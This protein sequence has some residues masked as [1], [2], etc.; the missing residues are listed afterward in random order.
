[1]RRSKR[2]LERGSYPAG[3]LVSMVVSFLASLAHADTL[4][5]AFPTAEGFGACTPGGRGG[6]VLFVTTLEDY[7][8]SKEQSIEGSFRA[9]VDTDGPR[10]ILFRVGGTIALKADLWI[11]KPYATIAGQSAPGGGICIRDYQLVLATN[12]VI[13]RH[14]RIRSGDKTRQEQMA[15]GIFGGNNSIVDHCSMSWAIDEV[16]SSFGT[17]HNL[18]VQW[19]IISEGLSKSFHPKGEHSKGSILQGDGGVTLHHCIYAHNAARNARV[20]SILLDFRNNIVYDWGYRCGYTSGGPI[21]SNYIN[22]Y[23]KPGPSTRKSAA[24]RVFDPGDDMPRMYLTGNVLEGNENATQYN[25]L[26]V[27]SPDEFNREEMRN[28]ILVSEAFAVPDVKT[29]S[30]AEALQRVILKAGA[31]KPQRDSAD[32]RLMDEVRNG[33]GTIIDSTDQVGGW[34]VLE[35]GAPLADADND[36]MPDDWETKYNL[37]ATQASAPDSD[38]DKDGYT[39][40]EEFLN[41]TNPREPEKS[42][43][44]DAPFFRF[45]QTRAIELVAKGDADEAARAERAHENQRNQ[46]ERMKKELRVA[47]DVPPGPDAKR[48]TLNL[49]SAEQL[50]LVRIRAGSFL[51]GSPEGEGGLE[52]ERPQHKVNISRP[53]YMAAVKTTTAQ[54]CAVLG[55]TSR[56]LTDENRDLP[57]RETTWFEANDFCEVLSAVTGKKFRLP[58]EAEWEYACRA[59]TTT[60][61]N[62]GATI[63]SDQANFNALE[64]TPFNPV[65]EYRAKI[66]PG[67]MFPPNAWGLYDMHG[68]QAEYCQDICFRKYTAEEV[69]DPVNDGKDGARV[70]RGGKMGSKAFYV[71]SAYRYGYTPYVGYCFRVVMESE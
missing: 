50:E 64:E 36:G 54:F 30:A 17:V 59:G 61:F 48:V 3:L 20:D 33:T 5:R 14:L 44:V 67:R 1:M 8:P 2:N 13:L 46:I 4:L 27:E 21:F 51:M 70:L 18:T 71:R 35:Q 42:C 63:T 49:G 31:T 32:T 11:T 58:T 62:T 23:F 56:E 26:L 24:R 10:T 16:M 60:A 52:N 41:E 39:D 68:N 40:L 47:F 6:Q 15:L 69:T 55:N 9:A 29:E 65:G 45:L 66:T 22:N 37:N 25:A 34:P 28:R 38:V 57:A 19:S 7:D 12:D 43:T 53:F